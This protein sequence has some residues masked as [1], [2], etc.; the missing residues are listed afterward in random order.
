MP[1]LSSPSGLITVSTPTEEHRLA[2]V[3]TLPTVKSPDGR[4]ILDETMLDI[5]RKSLE[6]V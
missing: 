6:G 2:I 5:V 3:A 1:W 4:V